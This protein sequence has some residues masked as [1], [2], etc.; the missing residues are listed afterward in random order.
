MK[1]L[2]LLTLCLMLASSSLAAT[3]TY[4]VKG[5]VYNRFS[6]SK[7]SGATVKFRIDLGGGS[8]STQT[9]TSKSDGSYKFTYTSTINDPN[10]RPMSLTAT[11]G[12]QKGGNAW[13]AQSYS[14]TKD[15]PVDSLMLDPRLRV[16]TGVSRFQKPGLQASFDPVIVYIDDPTS[17]FELVSFNTQLSFEPAQ[18][19]CANVQP[20]LGYSSFTPVVDNVSGTITVD[21]ALPGPMPIGDGNAPLELFNMEWDV[22]DAYPPFVASV[23]FDSAS[24]LNVYRDG[25]PES[26]NPVF[27]QSDHLVGQPEKCQTAFQIDTEDEWEEGLIMEWP[28]E[29]IKPMTEAQW[30]DYK[31]LWLTPDE[32]E[33]IPYFDPYPDTIFIDPC[34]YVYPG[35]GAPGGEPND[36]GLVM[37]WGDDTTPDGNYASAWHYDYGLDPDLTNC[38]IQITITAPQFG[39]S[40]QINQV[41]FDMI[42]I[43]GGRMGWW[44][45]CGPGNPIP[46]NT[47]TTVTINTALPGISATTPT[48]SGW[49]T[50][51]SAVGPFD[52]TKVQAFDVDENGQWIFGQVQVPPPG[53]PQ[54]VGLWNYWHNL[55]VTKNS[56]IGSNKQIYVKWSQPPI[57]IDIP[58][59]EVADINGWDEWSNYNN[60]PVMAD[61]WECNDTRPITD[62]HWWGSFQGWTLQVPPSVMPRAFHLG[63]WTD[64]PNPDPCDPVEFSHPGELIWE[65]ICTSYVW[66]YA[67]VDVDPLN[68]PEYE[69]ESCFQFTQLLSEDE[70]FHQEPMEDGTPN[71]YWLSIAAI[72]DANQMN[73]SDFHEWGWKTRPHFY[74]DDAVRITDAT[75]V[76]IHPGASW[77]SGVPLSIPEYDPGQQE[78]GVS[79]DLAF[80]LTTNEPAYVDD[81]IDGDISGP[82]DEPDGNVDFFDLAEIAA[83]WLDTAP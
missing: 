34:L 14:E 60:M 73:S 10:G 8:S 64:V 27:N 39:A 17:S 32:L 68:R 81:P 77:V 52:I 21:A 12:G 26:L 15:C 74:N 54:F 45:A 22:P 61:D 44:W 7:V 51:G 48:A 82:N 40:G 66:N 42:D 63:I 79:W 47:P 46:W 50:I 1:K 38:T 41:S 76:P 24:E 29:S 65:N 35:D 16:Q 4:T 75:L 43:N 67:G 19:Q 62:I 28:S 6:L 59:T 69:N 56:S 80:E 9:K 30:E 3:Y 83:H 18:M 5:Y 49:A 71:V 23:K 25:V 72:W 53:Q 20:T 78:H 57:E 11:L 2:I 31:N 13:T 70:W 37:K 58:E 55:I 36:A 33:G